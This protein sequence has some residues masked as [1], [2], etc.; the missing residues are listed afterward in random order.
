VTRAQPIGDDA[1]VGDAVDERIDDLYARPP[2]EFV[3]ARAA[4]A[5]DLRAA[6][7]KAAAKEVAALRRPT[8]AAW[9]L[10][11]LRRVDPEGLDEFAA[12]AATLRAAQERALGGDRTADLRSAMAERR[13]AAARLVRAASGALRELAREPDPHVAP[14]AATLEAA[15]ADP[16]TLDQ[17]RN[18]RLTTEVEAPGFGLGDVAAAAP[19][20]SPRRAPKATAKKAKDTGSKEAAARRK[21]EAA[22][23][24]REA[25]EAAKAIRAAER[26]AEAAAAAL[27]AAERRVD[28]FAKRLQAARAA[29]SDAER[30]AR[31][32]QKE[33]DAVRRRHPSGGRT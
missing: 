31:S 32:A 15:A 30:E 17:L 1:A 26:K 24:K 29:L 6:G 23:S 11:Q 12:A 20:P 16:E 4:L 22:A 7:D 28:D 14:M 27:G 9:A 21:A 19:S 13:E 2:E 18:G 10:N 5:K 25:A 3:A 8:L 33:L